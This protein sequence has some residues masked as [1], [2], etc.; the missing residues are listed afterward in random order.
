MAQNFL[1]MFEFVVDDLIVTKPNYCA[2]EEFPTCCEV[3]FRNSVFVS[4]CD[5]EFGQCLDPCMPKCGK[6]CLFSLETPIS[7]SDKLHVHIYKKK[8]EQCKFL[9][10]CTDLPIK[11]VF[12][13]VMENFN[14]ENPNWQDVSAK[15][16]K[17]LPNPKETKKSTEIVDNDCD[18]YEEGRR[19]QLCPTSELTKQ[20]LPLFNLKGCQTGN[21]VLLIRLVA[22]GPAI[23][24]SFTFS[25]I[26]NAGCD[27]KAPSCGPMIRPSGNGK[28]ACD[29]TCSRAVG[30][31]E[32]DNVRN[33][34][35]HGNENPSVSKQNKPNNGCVPLRDP[36]HRE[37]KKPICQRYFACNADKGNPCDEIEDECERSAKCKEY[38]QKMSCCPQS[39]QSN[40][41]SCD[42]YMDECEAE[43]SCSI[44]PFKCEPCSADTCDDCVKDPCS[45][46]GQCIQPCFQTPRLPDPGPEAYDE[47]EA[48]LNGSGL[49]IRVLKDTHQVENICDGTEEFNDDNASDCNGKE[50]NHL[51][52]CSLSN[53]MQRSNF[54]RNHIKRRTGGHI[55]NHPD[56]PKIRANI[57]YS[58]NDNCDVENYHV[59]YSKIKSYC[60]NQN[61]KIDNY[62]SH[63]AKLNRYDEPKHPKDEKNCC[64]Q[65]DRQD[66][67]NI[68][69][70]LEVDTRKKGIEVCYKTC[71]ETDSDV[72]L[73]KLGSKQKSERKKN[74]IEIELKTPKLPV[75]LPKQHVT[76][77]T[78]INEKEL[79]AALAGVCNGKKGKGGKGKKKKK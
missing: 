34:G 65:V 55:I 4:I 15:H 63:R 17:T 22:I 72:F 20:L 61:N 68:M 6:S 37:I 56:L 39:E 44:D 36:C 47:F 35:G 54:A 52:D 23:V 66:I 74:N 64:V 79:D 78:Q 75:T 48:C 41:C 21:V 46:C 24:S 50:N 3:S 42:E 12:D 13:K 53:L 38:K 5:R 1:F 10:G 11:G 59:P 73:V 69:K 29:A 77:E 28:E 2:P 7:D 70:G 60:D 16:V 18:S 27:K 32:N 58:G 71:E 26:C 57:K 40:N 49:V 8:T 76:T 67:R 14:I 31:M 43:N 33:R 9:I 62:R 45:P 25:R 19:E 51:S 30:G